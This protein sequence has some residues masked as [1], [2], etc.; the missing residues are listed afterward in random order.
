MSND[1]SFNNFKNKNIR[2]NSIVDSKNIIVKIV[3]ISIISTV[4]FFIICFIF[5]SPGKTS[6]AEECRAMCDGSFSLSNGKC[7]CS[8]Y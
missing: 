6:T 5:S 2:D 4:I 8:T 1:Y 3:L 7:V